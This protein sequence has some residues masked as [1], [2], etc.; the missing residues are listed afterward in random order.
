MVLTSCLPAIYIPTILACGQN[1]HVAHGVCTFSC[2]CSTF[3]FTRVN[4]FGDGLPSWCHC[5]VN[6]GIKEISASSCDVHIKCNV[7]IPIFSIYISP[8][9]WNNSWCPLGICPLG[10]EL[11][12]WSKRKNS[13]V[14]PLVSTG[15]TKAW[16]R[17]IPW[18][19]ARQLGPAGFLTLSWAHPMFCLRERS[20]TGHPHVAETLT[21]SIYTAV[22]GSP[23]DSK[24]QRDAQ[25]ILP[26]AK[27]QGTWN[28]VIPI[29]RM[30]TRKAKGEGWAAWVGP[31]Q[32]LRCT[33]YHLIRKFLPKPRICEQ[34]TMQDPKEAWVRTCLRRL[35]PAPV[36]R[37]QPLEK[38][39]LPPFCCCH[40]P[41]RTRL[42][43]TSARS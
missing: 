19:L 36:R 30:L 6:R 26:K 43:C 22:S 5:L 29:P 24:Q 17:A 18:S 4:R 41:V 35:V 39:Y 37:H 32:V 3:S 42:R 14:Q 23:A 15:R 38:Q 12:S 33:S 21:L 1:V 9:P 25:R 27:S 11:N 20:S 10:N 2:C 7:H 31:A 40:Q 28:R 8:D 34:G 13:L 16:R